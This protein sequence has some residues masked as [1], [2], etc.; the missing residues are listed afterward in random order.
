MRKVLSVIAFC[1]LGACVFNQV[2]GAS[3]GL[4]SFFV[5]GCLAALMLAFLWIAPLFERGSED[6]DWRYEKRLIRRPGG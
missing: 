6:V 3:L 4:S 1:I 2:I 5:I